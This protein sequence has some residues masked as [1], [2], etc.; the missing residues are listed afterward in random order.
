MHFPENSIFKE[1]N[2]LLYIR[3]SG[4]AFPPLAFMLLLTFKLLLLPQEDL[5]LWLL[6]GFVKGVL[7]EEEELVCFPLQPCHGAK[8]NVLS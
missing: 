8:I 7:V 1:L 5:H 2:T 6:I 4:S 3:A